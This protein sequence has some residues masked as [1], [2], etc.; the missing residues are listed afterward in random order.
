MH[1]HLPNTSS[2]L[3][4][5]SKETPKV[6]HGSKNIDKRFRAVLRSMPQDPSRMPEA[7]EFDSQD[8]FDSLEA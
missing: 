1:R 4:C 5:T 8:A 3:E 7:F 2:A 6:R